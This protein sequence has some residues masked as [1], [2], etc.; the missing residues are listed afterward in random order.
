MNERTVTYEIDMQPILDA[1]K[2]MT[3][4]MRSFR[5]PAGLL[6]WFEP[7]ATCRTCNGSY[8]VKLLEFDV[9]RIC[10]DCMA[11]FQRIADYWD[12]RGEEVAKL[13]SAME[14][15]PPTDW[16]R[17]HLWL[18]RKAALCGIRYGRPWQ[19]HVRDRRVL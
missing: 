4:A 5:T 1:A 16:P 9:R 11:A 17:F 8:R 14:D 10:P 18:D 19:E 6:Q 12:G 7:Q 13:I 15:S 2:A 3:D